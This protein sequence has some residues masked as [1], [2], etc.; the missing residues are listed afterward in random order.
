MRT[1]ALEEIGFD[2]VVMDDALVPNFSSPPN[3]NDFVIVA[4]PS[5]TSEVVSLVKVMFRAPAKVAAFVLLSVL[6]RLKGPLMVLVSVEDVP[7]KKDALND[8]LNDPVFPV[9]VETNVEG[10]LNV[11]AAVVEV[12]VNVKKL[13]VELEVNGFCK[14]TGPAIVFVVVVLVRDKAGAVTRPNVVSVVPTV[15][16]VPTVRNVPKLPVW[17]TVKVPGSAY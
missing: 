6:V 11:F 8:E 12:V 10:P 9:S 2:D 4:P 13:P 1:P 17:L 7:V 15:R 5:V 3:V 14:F 16:Y